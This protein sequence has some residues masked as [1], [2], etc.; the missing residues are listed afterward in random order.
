MITILVNP[1][2]AVTVSAAVLMQ[3]FTKHRLW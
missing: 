2:A 1:A 3:V